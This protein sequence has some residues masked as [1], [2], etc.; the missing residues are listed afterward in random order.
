MSR[1][2]G[3][4]AL[5]LCGGAVL[6]L[7][8]CERPS[9]LK[10]WS[11]DKGIKVEGTVIARVGGVPITLEQFE[12][13]IEEI[14]LHFAEIPESQFT[15]SEQKLAYLKEELVPRYLRYHE[16]KKRGLDKDPETRQLLRSLEINI[17]AAQLLEKEMGDVVATSAEIEDFYNL[18]K[19]E[20][21]GQES[22]RIRE[23]VVTSEARAREVLIELLRGADFST[24]A[25]QHSSAESSI[26]GGDLGW[27]SRGERGPGFARFD[28]VAFSPSLERGQT[29]NI[30]R[31]NGDYY[32]VKVEDARGGEVRS[33]SELW[34]EIKANVVFLKQH[35]KIQELTNRLTAGADIVVYEERIR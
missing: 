5:I 1:K 16:A 26:R 20:F 35:Q 22:R 29:S 25:R 28:E 6:A 13:E 17:L 23:V 10:F 34:E 4:L 33:L 15:T 7:C 31:H 27:L 30:F 8:G 2:I 14:N 32:I 3:A 9:G 24:L 19:D 11:R 21:R 18:Y 12:R